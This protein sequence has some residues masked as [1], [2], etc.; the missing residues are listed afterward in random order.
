MTASVGSRLIG[1]T[2]TTTC[3]ESC[4][5]NRRTMP[6]MTA[7]GTVSVS[8]GGTVSVSVSG[9]GTVTVSG[10]ATG[11]HL[12][13]YVS[14]WVP[15]SHTVFVGLGGGSSMDCAK[16]INFVLTNGDILLASA[17]RHGLFLGVHETPDGRKEY[18]LASEKIQPR[19]GDPVT[20][21]QIPWE[22][23]VILE[24]TDGTVKATLRPL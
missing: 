9:G 16:G 8:G 23:M 21:W 2:Y 1:L 15:L 18:M 3:G 22:H 20:W 4:L 13:P 24:R 6:P 12:S 19:Q 14:L 5:T 11:G 10:G 7:S 17:Y